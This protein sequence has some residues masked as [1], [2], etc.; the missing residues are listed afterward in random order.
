VIKKA[1]VSSDTFSGTLST[2]GTF[3]AAAGSGLTHKA[4]VA[5]GAAAIAHK[6]TNANALSTA[7]AK[8]ASFYSDNASTEELYIDKDGSFVPTSDASQ[9]LG[10]SGARWNAFVRDLSDGSVVRWQILTGSYNYYRGTT[11]N[12]A[13]A[14]NHIFDTSV[15]Y[16]TAGAKLISIRNL[17]SEKAFLD[18]DG[19]YENTTAGN[20]IILKSPDGTRYRLT[21]ANGGT[22]SVAAA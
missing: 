5:D 19:Q 3:A 12:G 14:V 7:G 1:T 17:S 11:A 22:V 16:T 2:G 8:I 20:G 21:I 15:S 4:S 10:A 18:K 6:F 9:T 13:A